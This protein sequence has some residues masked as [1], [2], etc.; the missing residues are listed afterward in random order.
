MVTTVATL[1]QGLAA[2]YLATD[3][4]QLKPGD[5][6]LVHAAAGGVGHMLTQVAKIKGASVLGTVSTPEK[7][8]VARECGADHVII[9]S[10]VDFE[11]EVKRITDGEGVNVVY[12][13]VGATTFVKGFNCLKPRGLM[14]SYGRS[15]GGIDPFDSSVLRG[16]L[17]LT[18]TSL[19]SY[20]RTY[21]EAAGRV[22]DLF[23]WLS[24]GSLKP[25]IH[26]EYSLADAAQALTDIKDRSTVGKLLLRPEGS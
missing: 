24:D 5:S 19:A 7:A 18:R 15:S 1:V 22:R 13:A 12:D 26:K 25:R 20:T 21:E 4:Y 3:V 10:D 2:H 6:C 16:N 11:D 14:V 8:R 17:F 23:S 9:Y